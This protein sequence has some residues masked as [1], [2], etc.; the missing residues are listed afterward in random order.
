ML[1]QDAGCRL[2][3][4]VFWG[5]LG[6]WSPTSP[7]G[8]RICRED[9]ERLMHFEKIPVKHIDY[10][11]VFFPDLEKALPVNF[12]NWL[13]SHQ[14]KYGIVS[15]FH[16]DFSNFQEP[17]KLFDSEIIKQIIIHPFNTCDQHLSTSRLTCYLVTSTYNLVMTP[18]VPWVSVTVHRNSRPNLRF[19]IHNFIFHGESWEVQS[20]FNETMA[21]LSFL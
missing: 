12:D 15:H 14:S 19:K 18:K 2:D 13:Q 16:Y 5:R 21:F 6:S 3:L 7:L 1:I 9:S 8:P 17:P 20:F 10:I 4:F 11:I